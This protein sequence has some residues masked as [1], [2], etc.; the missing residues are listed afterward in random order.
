[1]HCRTAWLLRMQLALTMLSYASARDLNRHSAALLAE[2][3]CYACSWHGQHTE[4]QLEQLQMVLC[5]PAP[6][7]TPGFV[8]LCN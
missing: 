3:S 2:H 4:Q 6:S 8:S 1:M 5:N 7:A